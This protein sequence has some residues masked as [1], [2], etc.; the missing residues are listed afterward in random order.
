MKMIKLI[1]VTVISSCALV[2]GCDR[3]G[4]S[5]GAGNADPAVHTNSY[6]NNG[7]NSK[8]MERGPVANSPND[9]ARTAGAQVPPDGMVIPATMPAT[10]PG[11]SQ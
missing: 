4:G 7:A 1:A 6:S 10:M 8:A 3:P 9:S 2:F 11:N 5:A